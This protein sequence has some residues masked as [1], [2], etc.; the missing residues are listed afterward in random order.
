[1]GGWRGPSVH[2][3]A[4]YRLSQTNMHGECSWL[5]KQCG[6]SSGSAA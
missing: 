5:G 4:Y 6:L 1:M 3:F 2:L